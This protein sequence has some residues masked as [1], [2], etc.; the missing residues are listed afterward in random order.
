MEYQIVRPPLHENFELPE[1][2]EL[3]SLKA[4]D[5]VKIIF[6]VADEIPE[7]MW[8]ILKNND[9]DSLWSGILDNDPVGVKT[10]EKLKAGMEVK[11]HPLDVI[12]T[13]SSK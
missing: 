13:Q 9:D 1:R 6:Q 5:L 8:V 2:R 12:Q 4:N 3:L 10:Q 7:R 11:F